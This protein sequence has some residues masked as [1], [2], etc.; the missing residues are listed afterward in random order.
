[1]I[2]LSLIGAAALLVAQDLSAY[3]GVARD[4]FAVWSFAS[5]SVAADGDT[6][7]TSVLARYVRP[8]PVEGRSETVAYSIHQ[9]RFHCAQR[10]SDWSS[11]TNY[12]ADGTALGD[13]TASTAE[14][15]SESTPGFIELAT[16]VC[17][18]NGSV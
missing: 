9:I 13:G 5:G 8:L 12:A 1:M 11:G 18:L 7:T 6:R 2:S 16:Q 17:A 15:W 14:A 3:E 4:D 10:N